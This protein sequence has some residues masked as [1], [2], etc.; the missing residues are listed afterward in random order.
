LEGKTKEGVKLKSDVNHKEG[1]VEVLPGGGCGLEVKNNNGQTVGSY[2]REILL[3][4]TRTLIYGRRKV[5]DI[6][7]WV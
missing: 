7:R 2:R 3:E 1:G 4:P 6:E 5:K